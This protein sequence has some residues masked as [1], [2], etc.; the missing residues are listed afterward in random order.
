MLTGS[1]AKS[2]DPEWRLYAR[3]AGDDKAPIIGMLAALDALQASGVKPSVNLR[4]VFEGEEEAGSPHLAEYLEKYPK[5]LRPD[6]WVLC[7]GPVHQ[8]RRMELFFGARGAVD[9]ELTVY[10]P[11]RGFARRAL[12]ELGAESDR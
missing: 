12:R 8:S 9:L 4:F 7:D 6:A 3:S 5:I 11:V 10:G 1:K 2:I